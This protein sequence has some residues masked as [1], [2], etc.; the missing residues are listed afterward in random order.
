[1]SIAMLYFED[2]NRQYSQLFLEAEGYTVM[3]TQSATEALRAIEDSDDIDTLLADNFHLN[4]EAQH[5]FTYLSQHPTLRQRVMVV[6]L[7]AISA[8]Y[9]QQWISDGLIDAHLRYPF[10]IEELFAV[11]KASGRNPPQ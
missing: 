7:S 11:L 3:A 9:A 5:A 8:P 6:G 2:S 1:M 4:P 10:S